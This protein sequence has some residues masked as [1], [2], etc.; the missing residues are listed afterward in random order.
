MINSESTGWPNLTV[1]GSLLRREYAFALGE[2]PYILLS[3]R[4]M[5]HHLSENDAIEKLCPDNQCIPFCKASHLMGPFRLLDFFM[6]SFAGLTCCIP[7]LRYVLHTL[8]Y[9]VHTS[10]PHNTPPVILL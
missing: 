1:V 3:P 5:I 10:L 9:Q 7:A 8:V 6:L 2:Q 4:P